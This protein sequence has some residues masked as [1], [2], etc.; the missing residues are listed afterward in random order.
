MDKSL[1]HYIFAYAGVAA[2]AGGLMLPVLTGE[3]IQ[4]KSAPEPTAQNA[5]PIPVCMYTGDGSVMGMR[6]FG[7]MASPGCQGNPIVEQATYQVMTKDEAA[8][9][10]HDLVLK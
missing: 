3:P 7:K 1:Y 10:V 2:T 5:T 6:V 9:E 8:Q 4:K